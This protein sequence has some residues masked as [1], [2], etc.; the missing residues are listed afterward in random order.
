MCAHEC[1]R[2]INLSSLVGRHY[3]P[4]VA[5]ARPPRLRFHDLP[6]TAASL[7]LDANVKP[8]VVSEMLGHSEIGVTMDP[9]PHVTPTMQQE[10]ADAF[11]ALL[12]A[13]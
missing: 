8:A 7:P 3:H 10:A 2:P 4:I 11:D 5:A 6:H 9:Y 12:S 13:T 1:G